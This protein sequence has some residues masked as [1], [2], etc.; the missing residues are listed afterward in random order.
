MSV[1][2]NLFFAIGNPM[3][4]PFIVEVMKFTWP[5]RSAVGNQNGIVEFKF[6]TAREMSLSELDHTK[7]G[8]TKYFE[9]QVWWGG[10]NR[11]PLAE[12]VEYCRT[13]PWLY[14][15]DVQIIVQEEGDDHFRIIDMQT[16]IIKIDSNEPKNVL[17]GTQS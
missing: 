4:V 16:N 12:F 11:L 2:T 1:V 17:P 9:A 14:P 7:C 13:L 6:N 3:D 15:E 8:G 5:A 10:F